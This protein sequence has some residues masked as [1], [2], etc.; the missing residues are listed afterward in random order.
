VI[1]QQQMMRLQQAVQAQSAGNT[2]FAESEYRSLIAEKVATPQIF[3]NL[4]LICAHSA[5]QTEADDLWEKALSIDPGFLEARMN[6][7]DSFQQAR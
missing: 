4:A 2:A 1:S 6:L 7:A 3:C 5:R